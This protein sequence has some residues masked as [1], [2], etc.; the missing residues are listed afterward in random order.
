LNVRAVLFLKMLKI[1]E[2]Q[3]WRQKFTSWCIFFNQVNLKEYINYALSCEI[4]LYIHS[5]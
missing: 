3:L 2:M 4:L 1:C 5:F